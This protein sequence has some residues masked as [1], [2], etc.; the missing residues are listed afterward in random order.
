MKNL[1]II[2]FYLSPIIAIS[3]SI[4]ETI[5][6]NINISF[7]KDT[8]GNIK[9]GNRV[10][11]KSRI[12]SDTAQYIIFDYND[13]FRTKS[14][15][16]FCGNDIKQYLSNIKE[17]HILVEGENG[18]ITTLAENYSDHFSDFG[19]QRSEPNANFDIIPVDN[20]IIKEF[21]IPEYFPVNWLSICDKNKKIRLHYIFRKSNKHVKFTDKSFHIVSDWVDLFSI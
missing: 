18:E 15:D 10:Y 11:I 13:I 7:V 1:L 17:S 9:K 20:N 8:N 4:D 16:F 2:L 21:I 5:K 14:I 19:N 6:W 12:S 3:Q